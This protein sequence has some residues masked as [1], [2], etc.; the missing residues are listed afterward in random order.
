MESYKLVGMPNIHVLF[1]STFRTKSGNDAT[2]GV[3]SINFPENK[4][5]L[6][7][8]NWFPDVTEFVKTPV[9]EYDY[10]EITCKAIFT[11]LCQIA[12]DRMNSFD[13]EDWKHIVDTI[14]D[15]LIRQITSQ[16][17]H[18][19]DTLERIN[20]LK[21]YLKIAAFYNV[22]L[23]AVADLLDQE[24]QAEANKRYILKCVLRI[25][26][27]WFSA[28]LNPYHPLGHERMNEII[29]DLAAYA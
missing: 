26:R 29:K 8:A 4:K 16:V 27:R 15:G 22:C 17:H 3:V 13:G 11:T 21:N 6:I 1:L 19:N 14:K 5:T 18:I 7:S 20:T 2:A 23:G 10:V 24:L 9:L 12:D 28:W 25:Q